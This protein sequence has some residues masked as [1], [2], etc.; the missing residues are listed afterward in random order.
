MTIFLN[1]FG[2]LPPS[3]TI[4]TGKIVQC[5]LYA[6]ITIP[7]FGFK[8]SP[9]FERVPSGNMHTTFSSSKRSIAV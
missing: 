5:V 3:P 9:V 4:A 7:I 6:S 8:S 2:G 1:T